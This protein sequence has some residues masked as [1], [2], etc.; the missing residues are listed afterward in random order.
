MKLSVLCLV[1]AAALLAAE[2]QAKLLRRKRDMFRGQGVFGP[3]VFGPG[4]IFG[5]GSSTGFGSSRYGNPFADCFFASS[6]P[7]CNP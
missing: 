5:A 2:S 1:V 7:A 4:G 3:G 6:S